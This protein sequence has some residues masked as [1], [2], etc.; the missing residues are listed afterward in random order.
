MGKIFIIVV[1][2]LIIAVLLYAYIS[3]SYDEETL[4][5]ASWSEKVKWAFEEFKK[6]ISALCGSDEKE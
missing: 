1:L 5:D 3:E 4:E 6:D 2:I